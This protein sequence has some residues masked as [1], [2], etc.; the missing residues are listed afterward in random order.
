MSPGAVTANCHR[1]NSKELQ[2]SF[3]ALIAELDGFCY[4]E[5]ACNELGPFVVHETAAFV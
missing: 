5:P 2:V 1:L 3:A 4:L